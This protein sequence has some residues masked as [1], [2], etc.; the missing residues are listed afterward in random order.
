MIFLF[1]HFDCPTANRRRQRDKAA[2]RDGF[3]CFPWHGTSHCDMLSSNNEF[4]D[5]IIYR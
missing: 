4:H 5:K 1:L 3:K 2:Q